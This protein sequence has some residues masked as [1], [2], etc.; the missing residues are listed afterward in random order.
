MEDQNGEIIK[1]LQEIRDALGRKQNIS[2]YESENVQNAY[3]L[4]SCYCRKNRACFQK[5]KNKNY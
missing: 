3:A 1:A 5:A 2:K 4:Y